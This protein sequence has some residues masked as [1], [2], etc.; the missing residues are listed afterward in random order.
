MRLCVCE[1]VCMCVYA[2]SGLSDTS[3]LE[4]QSGGGSGLN[5]LQRCPRTSHSQH[6]PNRSA[7]LHMCDVQR[8]Y[9]QSVFLG[10][11]LIFLIL[12]PRL[13]SSHP[14]QHNNR[15]KHRHIDEH[16]ALRLDGVAP[17]TT[18]TVKSFLFF[19]R[20]LFLLLNTEL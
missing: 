17:L 18:L 2:T 7:F 11:Q 13:S 5:S 15:L 9:S 3:A 16:Q 8:L 19:L 10:E 6:H 12:I 14:R 1:C 20:C 4:I